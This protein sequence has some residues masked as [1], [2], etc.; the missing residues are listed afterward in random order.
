M[1]NCAVITCRLRSANV[2]LKKGGISFHR[3][4]K[5]ALEKERELILEMPWGKMSALCWGDPVDPP[6]LLCHGRL[7]SCS[8]FRPLVQC[9]PPKYFYVS[10]EL[11][12]NGRSDH[13]PKRGNL[14]VIDFVPP[15]NKISDYFKW[16]KFTYIGHSAG[17]AIGKY[18]NQFKPGLISRMVDVEPEPVYGFI[19]KDMPAWYNFYCSAPYCGSEGHK[20]FHSGTDN[21]PKYTYEE[22]RN[23]IMKTR[24]LS[25]DK[26][27]HV[28]ERCLVASGDGLYRLT[29][30]QRFKCLVYSPFPYDSLYK[31]FTEPK[32]P[33]MGMFATESI[34]RNS[35]KAFPFSMDDTAW[36]HGNYSHVILEGGHDI[37]LQNPEEVALHITKF[38]S[39]NPE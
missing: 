1:L 39:D 14:N 33:T 11:P 28:L 19:V 13:Y 23:K 34:A 16:K 24:G 37:H 36:K 15:I 2:S 30:D 3:F 27:E 9:L 32:T 20:K 29:F 7:D 18:L 21:S 8:S 12:G 22:I 31:F 25:E 5:L 10:V 35:Y 26:V 38:L 6:I 4:S 17:A